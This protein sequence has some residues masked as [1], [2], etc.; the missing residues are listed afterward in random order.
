MTTN[1]QIW[2][3]APFEGIWSYIDK[4]VAIREPSSWYTNYAIVGHSAAMVEGAIEA[5]LRSRVSELLSA[6]SKPDEV[7]LLKDLDERILRS[8]GWA[9][10]SNFYALV[11]GTELHSIVDNVAHEGIQTLFKLRNASSSHGRYMNSIGPPVGTYVPAI[12]PDPF[13][14]ENKSLQQVQTYL[15]KTGVW[16]EYGGPRTSSGTWHPPEPGSFFSGAAVDRLY[17]QALRYLDATDALST[18]GS[19][20]GYTSDLMAELGISTA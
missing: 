18:I 6:S 2:H 20:D 12:D 9:Q 3:T 16:V 19:N 10:L 17:G 15:E 5:V 1:E 13:R 14:W 11:M 7:R 8:S 4:L